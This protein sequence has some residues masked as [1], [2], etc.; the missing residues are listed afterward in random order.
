[1]AKAKAVFVCQQCAHESAKWLGKC[2]QCGGW[3]SFVEEV[4]EP[5]PKGKAAAAVRKGYGA[6]SG[7]V[8]R[9]LDV[10]EDA[11]ARFETGIAELDRVLGGG[12]VSGGVVMLGGDPGIGKSTLALQ[13]AGIFSEHNKKVLY[14]SGEESLSQIRMRASRLGVGMDN[15]F[16]VSET[17][18]ERAEKVLREEKP[19]LAII[20][21]LQ[22]LS[23]ERLTSAPGSVAQLREVTSALTQ[24]AKGVGLPMILVGHVTK[25][26][27]IAGPK[28][29]EHIVDT[30]LYFET[31]SGHS[32]RV[33]RAVKNRFGSTN[34]L[35][36]FE[37]QS[38]GLIEV[39]N[40]SAAFLEERAVGA[41]GSV[42][43]PLIEGTRPLL[44]EIQA[45]ASPTKYGP[46]R[47]TA[48]GLDSNRVILVLNILE[49]HAGVQIDGMDVFVNVTGGVRVSE[50]AADLAV[51]A[52]I[53]SSVREKPLP[54]SMAVFGE[55]GLTGEIRSV[56]QANTRL[57]EVASL[58]FD[59]CM[60][61]ARQKSID[62][63]LE[64][65]RVGSI[66]TAIS[67]LIIS[68]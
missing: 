32:Y 21:S 52:A 67:E 4:R 11:K 65:A 22:T 59:R 45:L 41:P 63:A 42:V 30:V 38:E 34:E 24:I 55:L 20:D 16:V 13:V 46:S 37:M 27:A 8:H 2:P 31:Q 12:F 47:V 58:G 40:P 64:L 3:N 33:L 19:D 51:A 57:G 15:V 18:M 17:S 60:V 62:A 1:M 43:F 53:V 14:M 49:K 61:P 35:G 25:E 6:G 10:E 48:V 56:S 23:T 36:V 29:L 66:Q 44:V 28:V 7:K 26:G 50:P 5:E 39:P 68:K 54:P 9:L